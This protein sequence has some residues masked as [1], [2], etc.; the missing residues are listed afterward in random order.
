M[1]QTTTI[2]GE[3]GVD[4]TDFH[5]LAKALKLAQPT[6]RTQL[7]RN[8]KA[9]GN[10]VAADARAIASENSESIP[11]TIKTRV[12]GV[13]VSVIAGGSAVPIAG[14]YEF[15]NTG[16]KKSAKANARGTFRH[17]VFNTGKWVSQPRYAYLAPAGKKNRAKTDAA[18]YDALKSVTDVLVWDRT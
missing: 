1:T 13:S 3:G 16:G 12:R 10:I 7:L 5:L 14:L 17:P 6:L 15:G 4:L 11:P 9:V 2:R 18:I 8:L